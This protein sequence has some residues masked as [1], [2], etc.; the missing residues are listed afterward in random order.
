MHKYLIIIL[1][2]IQSYAHSETIKKVDIEGNNRISNETILMFSEINIG[3]DIN[4]KDINDILKKLYDTNFFESVEVSLLQNKLIIKTK[5]FPIVQN[6]NVK[7]IEKNSIEEKI[8]DNIIFKERTSFNKIYLNKDRD[9]LK[10]MK[11]L[12]N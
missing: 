9:N 1:F 3:D 2:F 5:E 6:V 12:I 8:Y 11:F 7:G 4:Q 10:L